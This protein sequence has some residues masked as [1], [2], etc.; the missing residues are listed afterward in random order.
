MT[1]LE[2][3]GPDTPLPPSN[4]TYHVLQ[5]ETGYGTSERTMWM[6]CGALLRPAQGGWNVEGE[7]KWF[8]LSET[9]WHKHVNC[10]ACLQASSADDT[11]TT[12]SE[13]QSHE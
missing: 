13:R 5:H 3:P 9:W 10:P 1:A 7:H 2:W 11:P 6:V 4:A 8:G 12:P